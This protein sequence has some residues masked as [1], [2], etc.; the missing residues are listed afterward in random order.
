MRVG[1]CLVV[2]MTAAF[3]APDRATASPACRLCSPTNETAEAGEPKAPIGIEVDT[4]LDFDRLIVTGA[5]NGAARLMPDGTKSTTGVL[6]GLRGRS[7]VGT[8]IIRGEP[9]RIIQ[10]DLPSQI[11]LFGHDGRQILVRR[12][13]SDLPSE[14][15]LDSS[16]RL[17]VRFGGELQVNGEAEGEYR[18]EI[19]I[20]VQYL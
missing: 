13:A 16:G 20:I 17:V 10:V 18:G 19:P 5:G 6:Q 15:R 11:E 9:G 8:V 4:Y 2:A 12:I 7:V 3:A 14:P 1:V